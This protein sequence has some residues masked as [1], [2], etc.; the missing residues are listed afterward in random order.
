[1]ETT[2][3]TS[4]D[5]IN[6]LNKINSQHVNKENFED[7]FKAVHGDLYN[8]DEFDFRDGQTPGKIKCKIHTADPVF[9]QTPSNHI[10]GHHCPYC[11]KDGKKPA[12]I[13][14]PEIINKFNIFHDNKY[15][16]SGVSMNNNMKLRDKITIKC[17]IHGG[18][19]FE[20]TIEDHLRHTGCK[21]CVNFKNSIRYKYPDIADEW[22]I[23]N[24]VDIDLVRLKD[25]AMWVC[26]N[27]HC[28]T[29][30]VDTK[31]NGGKCPV[32]KKNG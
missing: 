31:K 25:I 22:D 6:K 26:E 17:P 4:R 10:K 5:E 23:N 21:K 27:N 1:M 8:Y 14:M 7:K 13:Y 16:Y 15:D 11:S 3:I 28:Y 30:R 9:M 19:P 18:E 32:C 20:Q 29:M 2:K 24:K 12:K